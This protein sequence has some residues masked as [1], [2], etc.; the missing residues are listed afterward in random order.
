MRID[1]YVHICYNIYSERGK[2]L[3]K[4]SEVMKMAG[5]AE[6]IE[7]LAKEN[8]RFRLRIVEL[9]KEIAHLKE[10]LQEAESSK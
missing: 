10:Q 9:E 2:T 6:I 4:G 8:E 5:A 1:I 3:K 7:R